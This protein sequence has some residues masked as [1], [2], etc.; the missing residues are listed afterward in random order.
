VPGFPFF[1]PT[2]PGFNQP[3]SGNG[4]NGPQGLTNQPGLWGGPI[5]GVIARPGR[6]IGVTVNQGFYVIIAATGVPQRAPG[7]AVPP[8]SAVLVRAHNGTNAGNT[9]IVTVGSAPDMAGSGDPI[10]PD[11]EISWPTNNSVN[12]WVV[13]TAGDGIRVSIQQQQQG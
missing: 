9:N 10:T 13:G 4:G 1:P 5:S 8:G 12:L 11:S 6:S 3:G 7:M 2:P